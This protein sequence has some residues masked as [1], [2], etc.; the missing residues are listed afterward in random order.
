MS[1]NISKHITYKEATH[2]NTATRRG[3]K[4][5]PNAKQLAAMKLVAEKVF[6]P[7]REHFGE[8]IRINSFFRCYDLNRAIGGSTTSQHRQ[9]EAIDVDATNGI[10]N[11]QL[12]DYIRDNLEYDQLICEFGTD[13]NPDWVH[14]SYN[15]D[16]KNRKEQL[17]AVSKGGR[18]SYI[19][20]T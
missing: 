18:T 7:T 15:S 10:T 3:I 20:I 6:E 4:N 17:K 12:Y 5:V 1:D 16:G 14:F 11:K 9:G 2:S 8:P 19:L 13:K